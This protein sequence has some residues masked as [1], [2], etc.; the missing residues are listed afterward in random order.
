MLQIELQPGSSVPIYR[1]IVDQI[2][3]A[4]A[5]GRLPAGLYLPSIRELAQH[6]VVNPNTVARAYQQLAQE[7]VIVAQQG[8]GSCIA[9]R[10]A[11]YTDAERR[12]RVEP[13]VDAMLQAA[14]AHNIPPA[15]LHAWIDDRLRAMG[16]PAT[17]A[18]P[19]TPTNPTNA[20]GDISRK[21]D[22]A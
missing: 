19:T 9:E 1:Q 16:V 13:L 3:V 10:R 21:G 7:G 8:R 5:T 14:I 6:L 4:A 20:S 15:E 11:V 18:T 22:E 17:P 12:R 2:R